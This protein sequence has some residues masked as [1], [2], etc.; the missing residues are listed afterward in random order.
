MSIPLLCYC[1]VGEWMVEG[2]GIVYFFYF[3]SLSVLSLLLDSLG[4]W[5][6]KTLG[7]RGAVVCL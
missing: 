3:F 7:N 4:F 1:E 2:L 6:P 5:L